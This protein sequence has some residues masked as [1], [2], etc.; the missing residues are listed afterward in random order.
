MRTWVQLG[1]P[2]LIEPRDEGLL[3]PEPSPTLLNANL[4]AEGV[5]AGGR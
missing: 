4:Q 5:R 3:F 1:L 2:E